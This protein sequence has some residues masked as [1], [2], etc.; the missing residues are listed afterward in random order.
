[1]TTGTDRLATV[2]LDAV[3]RVMPRALEIVREVRANEA[4]PE[5][6]ALWLEVNGS[7]NGVFTYDL[8]FASKSKIG[9]GDL[10]QVEGDLSIVIA[11]E[12]VDRLRGAV[13]DVNEQSGE[14]GLVIINPN[15][16][17]SLPSAPF[18]TGGD[19]SGYVAQRVV[20]VLEQ[21]V[22]PQ[23][24][25][26]GGHAGL[27]AVEG[28]TAYVEMSGGCQGCGMARATLSQGIAVAIT[29]AVAEITEVVD[30]TDHMSGMNPYF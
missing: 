11:G 2:T 18:P 3:I 15:T 13:L 22:N 12:S 17:P 25:M 6:L 4:K 16:P 7:A 1:L 9:P 28:S 21:D 30:V 5:D 10:A 24:A 23:I 8:W 29:D 27:V 26:H 19:L 14:V 20:E